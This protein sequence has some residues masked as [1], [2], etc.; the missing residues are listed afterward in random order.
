MVTGVVGWLTAEA[1]VVE[2]LEVGLE[3]SANSSSSLPLLQLSSLSHACLIFC[4]DVSWFHHLLHNIYIMIRVWHRRIVKLNQNPA[5]YQNQLIWFG[6]R[7]RCLCERY[8][9]DWSAHVKEVIIGVRARFEVVELFNLNCP[10]LV[11]GPYF[12]GKLKLK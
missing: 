6:S 3:T 8:N 2:W 10:M 12:P 5:L 9:L 7:L 4:P 11:T 1:G